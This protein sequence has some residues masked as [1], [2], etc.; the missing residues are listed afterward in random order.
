M[1]RR[2]QSTDDREY[3]EALD[4]AFLSGARTVFSSV[5]RV[6]TAV[7][8]LTVLSLIC[9]YASAMSYYREIGA[10]WV[11]PMVKTSQL[12]GS[13]G[14]FVMLT[15]T[16]CLVLSVFYLN[17][18]PWKKLIS[19]SSLVIA[20][21]GVLAVSG[22]SAQGVE[23]R[24][25]L[26]YVRITTTGGIVAVFAGSLAIH[27]TIALLIKHDMEWRVGTVAWILLGLMLPFM[28]APALIATAKAVRDASPDHSS[29]VSVKGPTFDERYLLV[30][31][32]DSSFL[33]MTP[34]LEFK[35]RKFRVVT[36]NE[37]AEIS[38]SK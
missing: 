37:I 19:R 38:R 8:G 2:A 31:A 5:G 21:L 9:G 29:L 4:E 15:A 22:Y 33:V 28:F 32:L 10:I 6:A 36:S 23:G 20:L 30:T 12:I 7:A 16:L 24:D 3:A 17:P 14:A 13:G 34:N 27:E 18:T 25:V 35:S 1:P 26:T 11:V